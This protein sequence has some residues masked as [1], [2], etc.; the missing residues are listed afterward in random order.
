[1]KRICFCFPALAVAPLV[2]AQTPAIREAMHAVYDKV[3]AAYNKKDAK[4]VIALTTPDYKWTMLDGK[5]LNHKDSLDEIKN[6]FANI[7]SGKWKVD[8]VNA[9]GQGSLCLVVARYQFDGILMDVAKKTYPARI[10]STER[11]TWVQTADG[12]RQ[13]G[14]QVLGQSTKTNGLTTTPGVNAN[15]SGG[16]G[17]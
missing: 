5:T 12:W 13:S 4:A 14:D 3:V 16:S 9:V 2:A 8:I 1:M 15:Q 10:V 17:P 7:V 6:E 11:Q